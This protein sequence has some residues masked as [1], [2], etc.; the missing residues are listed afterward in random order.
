M[1][2]FLQH[3]SKHLYVSDDSGEN[4]GVLVTFQ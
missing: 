3:A 4:L 2:R 1:D